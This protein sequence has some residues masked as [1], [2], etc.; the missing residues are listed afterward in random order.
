MQAGVGFHAHDTTLFRRPGASQEDLLTS[1]PANTEACVNS[2][3]FPV[4]GVLALSTNS[5]SPLRNSRI[6][7]SAGATA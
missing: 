6:A 7:R 4:R 3:V 1:L 2:F 5:N